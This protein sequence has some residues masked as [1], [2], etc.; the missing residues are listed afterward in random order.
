MEAII[1]FGIFALLVVVEIL[2]LGL[3]TIWFAAGAIVAFIA[4]LLGA[5]Q[6]V[7]II[8]FV[9]VSILMLVFTRPIAQKYFNKN[10]YKSNSEGLIGKSAKITERV[11]NNNGTGYAIVNGLEWTARSEHDE[12]PIEKGEMA[13]I[14]SISGVKLIVARI[15]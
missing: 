14:K 7:Q 2:T 12:E 15:S 13:E 9:V 10:T 1:W 11:D 4:A 6:I 5:P 8:L 3:T